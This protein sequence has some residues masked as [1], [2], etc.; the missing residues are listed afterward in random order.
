VPLDARIRLLLS[1][2][3]FAKRKRRAHKVAQHRGYAIAQLLQG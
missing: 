3:R 1:D 2:A